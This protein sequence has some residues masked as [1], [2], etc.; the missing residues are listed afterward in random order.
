MKISVAFFLL[1][2]LIFESTVHAQNL[3]W[4][5][6]NNK[7]RSLYQSGQYEQAIVLVKEALEIA[8][9]EWGNDHPNV[10]QT[11]NNLGLLY[12]DQGEYAQAEPVY[13]R[14]LAI[15]EKNA[16]PR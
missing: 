8:Q 12:Q 11:L 15:W 14:S 16:R 7:A 5:N 2:L 10:A 9:K 1:F 13:K 6:L 3:D 4:V